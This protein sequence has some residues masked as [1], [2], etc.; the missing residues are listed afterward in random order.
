MNSV[1]HL[2][3]NRNPPG[4]HNA[5]IPHVHQHHELLF[6]TAGEGG[7]IA[8]HRRLPLQAGDLFFFPAGMRHCS[9]FRP[10]HKFDC[11]VLDFQSSLFTPALAGDEEVLGVVDK[12][13][14]FHGKVPISSSG[15]AIVR[16]I[17]DD[18][19]GEFQQKGSA[20]HAALKMTTMRLLVAIA[21]DEEFRSQGLRICTSPSKDDLI[22]EVIH[23]LQ[24]FY[25]NQITVNSV[26]DFCPLS[27]SHFHAVF[28]EQ[29][30]KTLVQYLTEIRIEKAKE[31]LRNT[32]MP[33]AEIASQTGFRASSYLGQI[34]RSA[35]SM[36]PGQ[37]RKRCTSDRQTEVGS[38]TTDPCGV[39]DGSATD[40]NGESKPPL[41]REL[42]P[43]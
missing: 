37:Y 31:L 19:L 17:L 18:L 36:S 5:D 12:M 6:C 24:A 11:F 27:R 14:R 29:T 7:Q 8:G 43:L 21:R 25:M 4:C 42:A 1:F 15:G 32:E 35:T 23:Y 16:Q 30:G 28:R 38:Y 13:G 22:G 10:H 3:W 26:L 2:Q 40:D 34:F 9:V 33:I 41:R 39:H 20:Y